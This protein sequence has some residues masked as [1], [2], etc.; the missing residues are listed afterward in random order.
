[1]SLERTS[2]ETDPV[3]L[4]LDAGGFPIPIPSFGASEEEKAERRMESYDT[5]DTIEPETAPT[6][7]HVGPVRDDDMS[8]LDDSHEPEVT[9]VLPRETLY[10]KRRRK[11]HFDWWRRF[12]LHVVYR[13]LRAVSQ[14]EKALR[15]DNSD[16][17]RVVEL[18]LRLLV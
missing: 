11:S 8:S 10:A 4:D 6:T 3:C 1:M 12:W 18:G 17:G 9:I 14:E 15:I 7:P 13:G 2:T 16:H 5:Q